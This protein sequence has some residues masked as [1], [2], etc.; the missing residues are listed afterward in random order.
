M[1]G[2]EGEFELL[3]FGGGD[4]D[5]WIGVAGLGWG[6]KVLTGSN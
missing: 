1:E 2:G 3:K 4:M 5:E 6:G